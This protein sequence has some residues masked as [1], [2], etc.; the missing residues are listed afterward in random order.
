MI[1]DIEL[2][3][4]NA[5]EFLNLFGDYFI[6][7]KKKTSGTKCSCYDEDRKSGVSDCPLC[8]GVGFVG[9]YDQDPNFYR[10]SLSLPTMMMRVTKWGIIIDDSPI[11]WVSYSCDV[12]IGDVIAITDEEGQIIY[13]RFYVKDIMPEYLYRRQNVIKKKLSLVFINEGDPLYNL[14]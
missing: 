3:R 12:K 1:G 5:D 9:G 7:L 6:L 14:I 4:K 10:V 8:F 2:A 11:G 13:Y